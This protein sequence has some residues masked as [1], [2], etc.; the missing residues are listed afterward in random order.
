MINKIILCYNLRLISYTRTR[1]FKVRCLEDYEDK[2]IK[3]I[4]KFNSLIYCTFMYFCL[5]L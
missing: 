3:E 4:Q 1:V 5:F 2:N